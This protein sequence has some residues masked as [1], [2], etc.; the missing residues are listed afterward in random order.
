MQMRKNHHTKRM[1]ALLILAGCGDATGPEKPYSLGYDPQDSTINVGESIHLRPL[2]IYV[3]CG[4]VVN[5]ECLKFERVPAGRTIVYSL[6]EEVP[7]GAFMLSGD[8]MVALAAGRV[9]VFTVDP[10]YDHLTASFNVRAV[11][12]SLERNK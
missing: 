9:R 11:S 10:R 7:T 2:I 5:P 1:L 3:P 12:V 6:A 8:T 4:S